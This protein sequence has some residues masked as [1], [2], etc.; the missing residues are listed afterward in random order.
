MMT[1]NMRELPVMP[2]AAMQ[3]MEN[4]SKHAIEWWQAQS[5]RLFDEKAPWNI[6]LYFS[7]RMMETMVETAARPV[8]VTEEEREYRVEATVPGIKANEIDVRVSDGTLKISAEGNSKG[9]DGK[10]VLP[11]MDRFEREIPLPSNADAEKATAEIHEGRLTVTVPKQ[12]RGRDHK[13]A[14]KAA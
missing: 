12:P 4:W 3:M 7:R 13:V 14:V 2:F 9:A 11:G 1:N 6:G 8:A 10:S 5:T